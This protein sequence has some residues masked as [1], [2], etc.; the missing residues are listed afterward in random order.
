ML[1]RKPS[2]L[3]PPSTLYQLE[4]IVI[5]WVITWQLDEYQEQPYLLDPHLELLLSPLIAAFRTHIKLPHP[6]LDTPRLQRISHLIYFFTKV[7]GAKTIGQS[8]SPHRPRP[9]A[10]CGGPHPTPTDPDEIKG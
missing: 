10:C 3:S 7:R 5:L 9:P 8:Q 6:Q 2:R 4:L 1:N